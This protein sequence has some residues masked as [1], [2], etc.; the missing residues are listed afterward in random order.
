MPSDAL[1]VVKVSNLKAVS[2]KVAKFAGALGLAAVQPEFAD[3]LASMQENL[4]IKEG[5]DTAG[6]MAFVMTK[7]ATEDVDEDELLM[8]LVP[9][10]DYKAF[11]GNFADA[12]TNGD[13]TTFTPGGEQEKH[14]ANWGKYAAIVQNKAL[15]SK[16]PGGLKLAGLAAK[17]AREKDAFI[18]A[19]IPALSVMAMPHL[20]EARKEGIAE[21]ERELGN[22]AQAK[23]F[24]P[25]ARAVVNQMLNIAEGFMRDASAAGMSLHL[26]DQGLQT[27]LM[28]EFKPDTY[29]A[30]VAS[31]FKNSGEPLMAGLPEG[32]EYF[33]AGGMINAPEVTGK[34]LA[35]L[36]DPISKELAATP[37]GKS[38]V[39][40]M[41]SIKKSAA[42]TKSLAFGYPAPTGEVGQDSVVQSIMVI[43]GDAKT[44]AASQKSILQAA[45]DLMKMMPQEAGGQ[46]KFEVTPG[47]KTV[48]DLKLDTYK[49]EMAMD[50]NNPQAA[51]AQ[52]I[53][54]M[55]YGEN[56]MTGVFGPVNND[57]FVL[58][59]GGTDE[60]I[61]KAV[62]AARN[63]KDTMTGTAGIK[64]V[65][66]QLPTPADP[67]RVHL[68]GQH[69]EHRGPLRAG[70][71]AAVQ[72]EA[73]RRP[74]PD[75]HHRHHRGQ[76]RP[77]RRV[78]PHE[79]DPV[80]RRRR[81]G[82]LHA[83]ARRRRAAGR[84][85]GRAV[86]QPVPRTSKREGR[87]RNGR[88]LLHWPGSNACPPG[89]ACRRGSRS[90]DAFL[91][92]D[93]SSLSLHR[94]DEARRS[95]G[96]SSAEQRCERP[97]FRASEPA[98]ADVVA[99]P[100]AQALLTRRRR[101]FGRSIA[102]GGRSG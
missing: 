5:V 94:D 16:K 51:Q 82:K 93:P 96:V 60:T 15:L 8:I 31:Q 70:E 29:G 81:H 33:A 43:R 73:P 40:A 50:P 71:R 9:V 61:Q 67:G 13:V 32:R 14:V 26:N 65:S 86:K 63:P 27:T 55:I 10:S 98:C 42:A 62:S 19:N 54:S 28:A 66:G 76:R 84:A 92:R 47:G 38:F 45:T 80:P 20:K 3:P 24:V 6:E 57:A 74:A 101:L 21:M 44:I 11:L 7:P 99:A 85:G 1:V 97:A 37:S 25:V 89:E 83:D 22:D 36:L 2:D 41:D 78:R 35:D 64:T 75:R 95:R 100:W 90:S 69:R 79:A 23:Q 52:A 17:E 56:G 59:Q 72:D 18:F 77:L 58:V 49:T 39:P 87:D 88:G 30:K 4:Q 68:P 91:L 12:K 53:M 46:M 48:G 102:S 34:V